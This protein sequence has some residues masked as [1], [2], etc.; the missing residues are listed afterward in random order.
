MISKYIL[1]VSIVFTMMISAFSQSENSLKPLLID[2]PG[3]EAETASGSSM[4]MMGMKMINAGRSYENNDAELSV[5]IIISSLANS[6][7]QFGDVE[8][9]SDEVKATITTIDGFKTSHAYNKED[10]SGSIIVFIAEKEQQTGIFSF[11]YE[12]I[13]NNQ[14]MELA[15]KFDWAK[16]K[17]EIEKLF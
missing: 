13:T 14:A 2:L 16:I 3:Y 1:T 5:T 12:G 4:N 8:L 15:K 17:T 9:E 6:M 11:S 10:G 7:E